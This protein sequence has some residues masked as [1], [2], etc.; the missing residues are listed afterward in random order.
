MNT[1]PKTINLENKFSGFPIINP[2]KMFIGIIAAVPIAFSLPAKALEIQILPKSP[3]LGDTISVVIES[4]NSDNISNPTVAVGQKTYPAFEIAPRKYRSFIPTTPLEK[5]GVRTIKISE[6]GQE[7]KLLVQVR[8]RKFPVQ[9]ITLPPGKAGVKATEHELKRVAEL[10]AL[11]TPEK[12]WHG[13]FLTPNTGRTSTKYGV[14]RYYNGEFAKDYYHRGQDYAGGEG[15][16]VTT[17]AAGRVALVGKVSQ[18]FRVHGNV[19][20][21]DHGQGVISIF[22]HLSRIN[23]QEGDFVKAG[24]KIGAVGSTG[25]STG[26]HLHWGLYVNGQ[27]VDPLPWKSQQID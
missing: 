25:A 7:K 21:I 19:V 23:V 13:I 14:R 11:Q 17:P 3:Q 6:A 16:A 2:A 8:D 27:S 20:G 26:P 18:G 22:M 15:S 9:R 5:A 24:E 12:Y 4:T 1:I 10:K